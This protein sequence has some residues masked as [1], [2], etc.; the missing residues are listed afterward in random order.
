MG[1]WCALWVRRQAWETRDER[2]PSLHPSRGDEH[3]KRSL[4]CLAPSSVRAP[5]RKPVPGSLRS[6][7]LSVE[8]LRAP[9][10]RSQSL[11]R[12]KKR[13][14]GGAAD[15]SVAPSP[16]S[17]GETAALLLA[18]WG[19]AGRREGGRASRL[20]RRLPHRRVG[21]GGGSPSGAAASG[22]G[23][24]LAR[25]PDLRAFSFLKCGKVF[26]DQPGKHRH[27]PKTRETSDGE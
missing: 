19:C 5:P 20:R 9:A 1:P 7:L 4:G 2:S 24:M 14:G 10:A 12:K 15:S 25:S 11:E 3:R 13:G 22:R 16:Q 23:W 21:A 26:G 27:V 17:C 18:A 8:P 6:A